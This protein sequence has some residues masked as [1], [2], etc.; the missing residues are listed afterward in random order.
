MGAG[1]ATTATLKHKGAVH[2]GRERHCGLARLNPGVS[3]NAVKAQ[4]LGLAARTQYEAHYER[5][6]GMLL[7][8]KYT[9][10]QGISNHD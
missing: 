2:R 7:V 3:P 9:A 5:P 6:V 1:K 10:L 4:V 8:S